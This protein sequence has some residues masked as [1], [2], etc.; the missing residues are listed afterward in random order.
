M[1]KTMAGK[2]EVVRDMDSNRRAE[3]ASV[4]VC[5]CVCGGGGGAHHFL[6]SFF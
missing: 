3:V 6:W 5:V 1:S 2:L 4:C